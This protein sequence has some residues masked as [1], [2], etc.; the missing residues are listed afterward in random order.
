MESISNPA[1]I[2]HLFVSFDIVLDN[3]H[4]LISYDFYILLIISKLYAHFLNM[5]IRKII[6]VK[7]MT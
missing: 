4:T 1:F 5:R 2:I 7:K 6:F 3:K